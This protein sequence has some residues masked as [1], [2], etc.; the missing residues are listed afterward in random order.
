M[1]I[2]LRV[3]IVTF[4]AFFV[5][6]TTITTAMS[7]T[8][9]DALVEHAP[10]C[11]GYVSK[12]NCDDGDSTLFSGLLCLS[13]VEIGC[14][15]V[16]DAQ[17]SAG[18]FWR[19]PR[20][21]PGNLGQHNSFS[22]DQALGVLAY[23]VA[24][25]DQAAANSWY[26]WISKNRPCLTKIGNRCVVRGLHRYCT[27]DQDG[28]CTITPAM[29]QMMYFVWEDI[30]LNPSKT[31]NQYKNAPLLSP[32]DKGYQIHLYAVQEYLRQQMDRGREEAVCKLLEKEPSNPFFMFLDQGMSDETQSKAL[33]LC[34]T[35][36]DHPKKQWAWERR[37]SEEAWKSSMLWD[38]IF[39]LN[40]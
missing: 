26:E 18:R 29:F 31:M 40:L 27:D 15:T 6:C 19:S 33:E 35:T 25:K 22:R 16:R 11:N 5:G 21:N 9:L 14:K 37:S 17:D 23:L 30:G 34:P 24:T 36:F 3:F 7:T 12:E 1:R 13:G 4:F 32:G 20:R 39:L 38:C 28:R 2:L 10:R 8:P